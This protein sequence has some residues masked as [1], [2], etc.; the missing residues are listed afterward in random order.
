MYMKIVFNF[1]FCLFTTVLLSQSKSPENSIYKR[2][3][4]IINIISYRVVIKDTSKQNI[5]ISKK[6]GLK[7][8][9]TFNK[10]SNVNYLDTNF[11]NSI[12]TLIKL[13]I[14][15]PSS[16][17]GYYDGSEIYSKEQIKKRITRENE[18]VSYDINGN[19]VKFKSI[20][21]DWIYKNMTAI[22]FTESWTI[23]P[24]TNLLKKEILAYSVL[25][26]V[27]GKEELGWMEYFTLFKSKQAYL[28]LREH[29][30]F[31]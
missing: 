28:N 13:N 31:D 6:D 20:S 15:S 4:N 30:T 21:S 1:I 8:I 11:Y 3:G 18:I 22:D 14:E 25:G 24:I 29:L 17:I 12:C 16:I 5:S 9:T 7:S 19:E 26:P 27:L 2:D 23:D 10:E